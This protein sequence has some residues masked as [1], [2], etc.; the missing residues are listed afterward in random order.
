[1]PGLRPVNNGITSISL[2]VLHCFGA[3]HVSSSGDFLYSSQGDE[4]LTFI[5]CSTCIKRRHQQRLLVLA[6]VA[7]GDVGEKYVCSCRLNRIARKGELDKWS[8]LLL[9][10]GALQFP[11]NWL[12]ASR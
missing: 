11:Q 9:S 12:K 5:S 3:L 10:V 4:H 2:L 6:S 7:Y 1:M 8:V